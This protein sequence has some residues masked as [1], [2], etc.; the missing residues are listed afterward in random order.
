MAVYSDVINSIPLLFSRVADMRPGDYGLTRCESEAK[1]VVE[2]LRDN[3]VARACLPLA[4]ASSYI[5]QC[6]YRGVFFSD[7]SRK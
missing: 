5:S 4:F 3:L 1:R 6:I 7:I 2:W